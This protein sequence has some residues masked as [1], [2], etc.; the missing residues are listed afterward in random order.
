MSREQ[1]DELLYCGS[2]EGMNRCIFWQMGEPEWVP[3]INMQV[4][5]TAAAK[6]SQQHQE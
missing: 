3:P 6:N 1:I 2:T 4:L 5:L